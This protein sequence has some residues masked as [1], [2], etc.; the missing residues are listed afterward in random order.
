MKAET[1]SV[2]VQSCLQLRQIVNIFLTSLPKL[3]PDF[4]FNY[5]YWP[6]AFRFTLVNC[7][8]GRF[9]GM[10]EKAPEMIKENN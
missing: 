10:K 4:I 3:F 1:T 5:K 9:T 7:C 8:L 6:G 2:P